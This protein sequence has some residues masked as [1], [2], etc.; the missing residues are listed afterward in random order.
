MIAPRNRTKKP[1]PHGLRNTFPIR[2]GWMAVCRCGW[3]VG[4]ETRAEVRTKVQ[5]HAR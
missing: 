5:E 2:G 4:A 3:G 1:P